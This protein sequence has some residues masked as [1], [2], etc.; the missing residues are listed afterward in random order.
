MKYDSKKET[1]II[2]GINVTH[3]GDVIC[4]RTVTGNYT[5]SRKGRKGDAVTDAKYDVMTEYR[6][7]VLPTSPQLAQ[8]Q[9]WADA[10]KPL[11]IQY[12]N[13]NTNEVYNST[14]AYLQTVGSQ[15]GQNDRE[16]TLH[17][18]DEN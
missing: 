16:Y 4:E 8:F 10:R 5:E 11:T 7:T 6:V 9:A 12:K 15:N 13:S 17:C 18:E 2:E 1:L 14:T 3:F